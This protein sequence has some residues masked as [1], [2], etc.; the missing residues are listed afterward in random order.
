MYHISDDIRAQKSAQRIC[1]ALIDC[2][3]HTSFDEITIA[4]LHKDY[5]IS[6]TTFYR[7]FDNTVDVLEYMVDRMAREILLNLC[8]NTPKELVINAIIAL[9]ERRELIELLSKS[10]HL[11]ILQKKGEEYLPM[12]KLAIGLD[13]DYAYKYFHKILAHL[14]PLALDIWVTNGQTDSPVELYNKLCQSIQILR[15]WFS[16]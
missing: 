9:E 7:L 16:H 15:M 13:F 14:I 11:D 5:L 12:S 1:N 8:G 4:D 3:K 6:R 10:G 2:A